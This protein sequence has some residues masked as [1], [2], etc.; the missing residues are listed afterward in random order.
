[1][2]RR[3]VKELDPYDWEKVPN[4][5]SITDNAVPPAATTSPAILSRPATGILGATRIT[6]NLMED[7]LIT[8]LDNNQEN[9]E[10]DN[11]RELEVRWVLRLS[12]IPATVFVFHFWIKD[13]R[14]AESV[15]DHFVLYHHICDAEIHLVSGRNTEFLFSR[16]KDG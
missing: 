8:S 3:G 7:N 12:F 16:I 15:N 2:K 1:M 5:T 14:N 4:V 10:P 13:L 11:R 6:D 9:I